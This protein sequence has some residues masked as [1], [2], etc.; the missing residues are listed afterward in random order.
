MRVLTDVSHSVVVSLEIPNPIEVARGEGL[1]I[2]LDTPQQDLVMVVFDAFIIE[3][4]NGLLEDRVL[5]VAFGVTVIVRHPARCRDC[6]FLYELMIQLAE[7]VKCLRSEFE[8]YIFLV[9]P[10]L[11]RSPDHHPPQV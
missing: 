7:D 10:R 9:P 6:V 2:C 8:L 11:P 1:E 3:C 5:F 4:W